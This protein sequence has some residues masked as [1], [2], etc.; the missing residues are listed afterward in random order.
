LID[1][2]NYFESNGATIPS[3]L[4]VEVPQ[5]IS[6]DGHFI[7][8]HGFGTGAWLATIFSDCD[9]D[10]DLQCN[11]DDID[12]LVMEIVAGTNDPQFDLTGDGV[13]DLL[14]RNAWLAQAG[15]ENLASGNAYLIADA[16]LDGVVDGLDFIEWNENRFTETGKWSLADF[17]ADGIT[18]GNDFIEWNTYKFQEADGVAMVPEPTCCGCL[19]FVA[20]L[21]MQR[22]RSI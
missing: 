17:N 13:V 20:V 1:L 6:A 11:I 21:L 2:R 7:V 8:G 22:K 19:L 9:F 12:A 4:I 10:S 18:D 16:N 3:G 15:A 14:D 5:A